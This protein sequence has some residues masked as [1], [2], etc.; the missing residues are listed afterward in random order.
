[1][2]E[3]EKYKFIPSDKM[4]ESGITKQLIKGDFLY[5]KGMN[6]SGLYFIK[7]GVVGLIN[8]TASGSESL[9]RIFSEGDFLG[10]RSFLAGEPYHANS[11]ILDD[12]EIVFFPCQ[13][14]DHLLEL[15]PDLFL[16][17]TKQIARD[18]RGS[19]D[20][21]NDL[22]GK[23]VFLRIAQTLLY[24]KTKEPKYNWT[25]R[26]IGEFCG[27]KTETVTRALTQLE[28]EGVIRKDG[29]DIIIPSRDH[30]ISF[31]KNEELKD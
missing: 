7:S 24:L 5:E 16:F 30:F 14:V 25:R 8:Y 18:L 4:M 12:S 17:L 19:E 20:R 6:P 13:S 15:Y 23:K 22:T 1:M 10:H 27:A 11:L 2:F 26:E 21:L 28:N 9:L 29:R 3:Y 31:L